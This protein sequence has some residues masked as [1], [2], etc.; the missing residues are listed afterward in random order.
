MQAMLPHLSFLLT[1]DGHFV[2]RREYLQMGG[3]MKGSKQP[4]EVVLFS[5]VPNRIEGTAHLVRGTRLSD[6]LAH[7]SQKSDFIPIT[8]C[9]IFSQDGKLLYS[10]AFLCINRRHIIMIFEHAPEVSAD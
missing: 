8:D 7:S 3:K 4:I 5:T 1:P 10:S 9:K 6:M 2:K